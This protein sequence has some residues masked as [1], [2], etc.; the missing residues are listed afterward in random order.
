M[1][2]KEKKTHG[3]TWEFFKEHIELEFILKIL[4]TFQG[5]NFVTLRM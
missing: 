2:Q 5:V 4:I 3:Y 1:R